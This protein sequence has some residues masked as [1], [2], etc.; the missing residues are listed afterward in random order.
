MLSDSG[1]S[2]PEL[3]E[4]SKIIRMIFKQH[5]EGEL[6]LFLAELEVFTETLK[7][8]HLEHPSAVRNY[9]IVGR[10]YKC[11]YH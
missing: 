10:K 11:Q 3:W 7:V 2:C 6:N 8:D 5:N 9:L 1:I 4:A